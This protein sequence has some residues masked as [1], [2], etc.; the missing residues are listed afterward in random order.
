MQQNI[1]GTQ[2]VCVMDIAQRNAWTIPNFSRIRVT[3]P[4]GITVFEVKDRSTPVQFSDL[5]L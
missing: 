5:F 2:K 3:Y 4:S 1:G